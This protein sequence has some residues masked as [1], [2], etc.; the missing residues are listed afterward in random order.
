VGNVE[1]ALLPANFAHFDQS[2][3]QKRTESSLRLTLISTPLLTVYPTLARHLRERSRKK[4]AAKPRKNAAH[5][6]SHG[7]WATTHNQAPKGRKKLR[8]DE[9][10]H[11][12]VAEMPVIRFTTL[13]FH[14]PRESSRADNGY[15]LSRATPP[16]SYLS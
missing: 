8:M 3:D 2:F 1:R 15:E 12:D 14:F 16:T 5:G 10:T 11:G 9:P 6:A 7:Y 4:S 13:S